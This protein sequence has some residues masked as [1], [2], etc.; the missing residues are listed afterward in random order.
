MRLPGWNENKVVLRARNWKTVV[1]G[2]M[3]C[4]YQWF[5]PHSPQSGEKAVDR[6]QVSTTDR[7]SLGN[8]FRLEFVFKVA[9]QAHRDFAGHSSEEA[10]SS[11]IGRLTF[12]HPMTSRFPVSAICLLSRNIWGEFASVIERIMARQIAGLADSRAVRRRE[13]GGQQI[14]VEVVR[15][16]SQEVEAKPA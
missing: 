4:L 9:R 10:R 5:A 15:T 3:Y 12:Y 16:P 2:R 13:A 8:D 7:V 1:D 11:D 14:P 6:R